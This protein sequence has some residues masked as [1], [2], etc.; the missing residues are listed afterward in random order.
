MSS[1]VKQQGLITCRGRS[2]HAGFSLIELITVIALLAVLMGIA[3]PAFRDMVADQKVR[4]VA[5]TLHSS[6]LLARAEAIKRNRT[7][8]LR[9]ATGDAWGDG[10]LIPDPASVNSDSAPIHRERLNAVVTI[11]SAATELD[12]RPSGRASGNVTFELQSTTDA[13]K[14]RCVSVGLDGRATTERGGC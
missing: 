3:I 7:I 10:W 11:T 4:T 1:T 13:T 6:I 5:A 2:A 12:F 14:K 8:R 9:P